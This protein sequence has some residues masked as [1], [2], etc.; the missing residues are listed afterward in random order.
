MTKQLS[1]YQEWWDDGVTGDT[2][3][4]TV[5]AHALCVFWD[6]VAGE[7]ISEWHYFGTTPEEAPPTGSYPVVQHPAFQF[8][9]D[10]VAMPES[11]GIFS[12]LA[13]E[14]LFRKLA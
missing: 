5:K 13:A 1:Y 4:K 9:I 10:L 12:A 11:T 6:D 14:A 2:L 7:Y 8:P 3:T